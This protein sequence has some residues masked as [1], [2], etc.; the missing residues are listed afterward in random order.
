MK[1]AFA[2]VP[3][4]LAWDGLLGRLP[5]W[6]RRERYSCMLLALRVGLRQEGIFAKEIPETVQAKV[7]KAGF[8]MFQHLGD[9]GGIFRTLPRGTWFTLWHGR[10]EANPGNLTWREMFE[11]AFRDALKAPFAS[12]VEGNRPATYTWTAM[13]REKAP[14][15][16]YSNG[17]MTV[18]QRCGKHTWM[19][20]PAGLGDERPGSPKRGRQDCGGG[21]DGDDGDGHASPV[22]MQRCQKRRLEYGSTNVVWRR[23]AMAEE[24]RRWVANHREEIRGLEESEWREWETR[25][26]EPWHYYH[27]R[28]QGWP[29]GVRVAMRVVLTCPQARECWTAVIQTGRDPEQRTWRASFRPLL[30]EVLQL[31]MREVRCGRAEPLDTAVSALLRQWIIHGGI[32]TIVSGHLPMVRGYSPLPTSR[33]S[34][35]IAQRAEGMEAQLAVERRTLREMQLELES[36][37]EA[38]QLEEARVGIVEGSPM[39]SQR[40]GGAGADGTSGVASL[41]SLAVGPITPAAVALAYRAAASSPM[42]AEQLAQAS[43]AYRSPEVPVATVAGP[44]RTLTPDSLPSWAGGQSLGYSTETVSTPTPPGDQLLYGDARSLF[45]LVDEWATEQEI[46]DANQI[47]C[48]PA[49]RARYDGAALERMG[50]M[51]TTVAGKKAYVLAPPPDRDFAT[52]ERRRQERFSRVGPAPANADLRTAVTRA[53]DDAEWLA[54]R[55]DLNRD[56]RGEGRAAAPTF[57]IDGELEDILGSDAL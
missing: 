3:L 14:A 18:F 16:Y 13:G 49:M 48:S 24:D 9:P 41:A 27:N 7:L 31:A 22:V 21:A 15:S 20:T 54:R 38:L 57:D 34:S 44:A 8:R 23:P 26:L 56:L 6:F 36:R 17:M 53:F 11:P 35:S 51:R 19:V 1:A 29:V 42:D 5:K 28:E 30:V 33:A 25:A 55:Q 46:M 50:Y 10:N 43:L 2:L 40:P 45:P 37:M 4:M 52:H 12:D 32:P 47:P 39:P